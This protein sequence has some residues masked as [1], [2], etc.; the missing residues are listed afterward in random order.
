MIQDE[1]L[2]SRA[3]VLEEIAAEVRQCTLCDLHRGRTHAVP[4]EGPPDAR[5]MFIGEGPGREEDEQ[6]RPFV[7]PAGRYLNALLQ[8]AGLV[9]EEVFITNIVKCRPPGNREPTPTEVEAC[10]SYLDGQI[11]CLRPHIICLLGRPATAT[12]LDPSATMGK[13]HGSPISKDGFTYIP[14]YHPAAALHN[15][16]LAPVLT[17]DFTRLGLLLRRLLAEE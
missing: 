12:L 9:R 15:Q 6:G 1:G 13:I 3:A 14:M 16:R 17:E 5:V 4:G 7:G 11:A 8:R 10:R 2:A